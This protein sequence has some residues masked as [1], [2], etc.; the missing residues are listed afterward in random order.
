MLELARDAHSRGWCHNTPDVAHGTKFIIW[1]TKSS[2]FDTKFIISDRNFIILNT[3]FIISDR[4]F[5]IWNAK[6]PAT[7]STRVP[8]A[9]ANLVSKNEEFCIKNNVRCFKTRNLV[10]KTRNFVL[11]M[12][13]SQKQGMCVKNDGFCTRPAK[14][15]GGSSSGVTLMR[16]R[17]R[18][19]ATYKLSPEGRRWLLQQATPQCD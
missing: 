6:V 8:T 17:G 15:G 11:K 18:S 13:N 14:S 9:Y 4:K 19:P 10:S 7:T 1:N 12:M 3:K 16:L 5:I 2:T